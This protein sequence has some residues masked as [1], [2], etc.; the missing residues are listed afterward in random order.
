M[1]SKGRREDRIRQVAALLAAL[2]L[3]IPLAAPGAE[4]GPEAGSVHL[5]VAAAPYE[6]FAYPEGAEARGLDVDLLRLVCTERGW[7]F[8]VEWTS[9][10]DVWTRLRD[11]QAD[12][13]VGALYVTPERERDFLFTRPY[14]RTGL[15]VAHGPAHPVRSRRDLAGL[16]LG[17]K[18]GATGEAEARRLSERVPIRGVVLFDDTAESFEA[19]NRGAVDAVL[20][21]YLNTLFLVSRRYQ[22]K[23]TV[24]R[25]AAGVLFLTRDRLA[26]PFRRDLVRLRDAFDATL[27]RLESGGVLSRLQEKWLPVEAPRDWRPLAAFLLSLAALLAVWGYF[28]LRYF[29]RKTRFETLRESERRYRDLIEGAPFGVALLGH[30]RILFANGAFLRLFGVASADDVLGRS[31]LERVSPSSRR[32]AEACLLRERRALLPESGGEWRCLKAD[33]REFLLRVWLAEAEGPEGR[34]RILFAEDVTAQREAERQ[35]EESREA[36]RLLVENQT[37]LVVKVDTEG[38]FLFV[39][40]SYCRLFGKTEGELLG[41]TFMPLVHEEDLRPTLEAMKDL[42]RPPWTCYVEQRARTVHGWRWLAWSDKAVLS[43][44]GKVVAIVGV[45][46]DIT[47]RKEAEERLQESERRFRG[48]IENSHDVVLVLG[49]EGRVLYASPSL[50]AWLGHTAESALGRS[51][52]EWVAPEDLPAWREALARAMESPARPLPA[53]EV[54]FRH[55]NGSLRILSV[56]LTNLLGDRAVQGVV[57]NARDITERRLAE[58]AVRESEALFRSLAETAEAGILIYQGASFKY[59]NRATEVITGYSREELLRMPF[60]EVVHPKHREM[61][62]ERGLTRQQGA[63][64]PRHYEMMLLTKQGETRWVD[65]TATLIQHEGRPAGIA[66]A[67]DITERKR[68]EEALRKKASQLSALLASSEAMAGKVDLRAAAGAMCRAAVEAF[69]LPLCWIGLVEPLTTEVSVVASAGRD[70]GYTGALKVTWDESP[71]GRGPVGTAIKTRRAAVMGVEDPAMAPWREMAKERG[72][73]VVCAVPLL[74]EEAVRGVAV[75]YA[76]EEGFFDTD[77]LEVLEI[78]ARHAT[79]AVVNAALWREAESTVRE[80][81][82]ALEELEASREALARSE[83]RLTD[84]TDNLTDLI[85]EVDTEFRYTYM[86]RVIEKI[87]GLPPEEFLGKSIFH[88]VFPEARA[89]VEFFLEGLRRDPAPFGPVELRVMDR[90]GNPR[91]IEVRGVPVFD[92]QGRWAGYRGISREVTEPKRLREEAERHAAALHRILEGSPEALVVLDGAGYVRLASPPALALLPEAKEGASL[93]SL[94]GDQSPDSAAGFREVL[95]GRR[96]RGEVLLGPG[97]SLRGL[98]LSLKDRQGAPVGALLILR[99]S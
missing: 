75:F 24:G 43:E 36:Y 84:L 48:L 42:H 65:F 81:A 4:G 38:R 44:D 32:E 96:E 70:E 34:R 87:G 11:G 98:V 40:P 30:G 7:T 16:L 92:G 14:L 68:V 2:A 91:W 8:E 52:E 50:A 94:L 76:G 41:R 83:H 57:V 21:D 73:S 45:G 1:V 12:M 99:K 10:P 5:K 9:F 26:F 25:S 79:M 62:K 77:T 51:L 49:E 69:G 19:L 54:R 97:G 18:R 93:E 78:F 37:D 28:T 17:V 35:L 61:V 31:L 59:V 58:M 85:W 53:V 13:A 33:G 6:P 80:L 46:R 3:W 72:F 29:Q 74:H 39:S 20:N 22:G 67:F 23:V 88:R 71:R 56:V 47:D 60:W 63:P 90:E 95:E 15:V 27:K 82:S 55:R 89:K 64:V 66:T 86:N